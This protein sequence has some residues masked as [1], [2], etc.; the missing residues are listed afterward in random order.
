VALPGHTQSSRPDARDTAV[1]RVV[2][3]SPGVGVVLADKCHI[4]AIHPPIEAAGESVAFVYWPRVS[5]RR[6]SGC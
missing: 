3:A 1:S 6:K 5:C 2:D 4:A